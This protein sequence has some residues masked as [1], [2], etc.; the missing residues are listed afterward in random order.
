LD[1][2]KSFNAVIIILITGI[3]LF[4]LISLAAL[5]GKINYI[6]NYIL[7]SLRNASNP[8][9]PIGPEWLLD[10]MLDVSALGSVTIVVLI[11][12]LT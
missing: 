8:S 7:L 5:S 11:T 2:I 9:I 12:I 10:F 3:I 4:C 1:K 6:D